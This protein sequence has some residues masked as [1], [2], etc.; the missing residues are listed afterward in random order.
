MRPARRLID[1]ATCHVPE[2]VFHDPILEAVEGDDDQPAIT[3]E[4]ANSLVEELLG[5]L[6]LLVHCQAE[7]LE[8]PGRGIEAF[9]TTASAALGATNDIGERDRGVDRG[10]TTL[11]DHRASDTA[12][13]GL[14]SEFSKDLFQVF[15][16]CKVHK[17]RG[18]GTGD[19]HPHVERTVTLKTETALGAVELQRRHTEIG[20]DT[21]GGRF[22]GSVLVPDRLEIAKVAFDAAHAAAELREPLPSHN[23]SSRIAI[24]PEQPRLREAV[25]KRVG[26]AT[27]TQSAVDEKP[28]GPGFK[29]TESLVEENGLMACFG[30]VGA[31]RSMSAQIPRSDSRRKSSSLNG[32][33]ASLFSKRSRFQ[34][35]R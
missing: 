10:C 33:S 4:Q 35:T 5:R 2:T 20:V 32:C 27:E 19:P 22:P 6:E 30:N 11:S 15:L 16:R 1:F 29:P 9:A 25:E 26:V 18:G 12:R 24:D 3:I 17:F 14:F 34:T 31:R 13:L 28:A 7:R 23:E 21:R 8:D